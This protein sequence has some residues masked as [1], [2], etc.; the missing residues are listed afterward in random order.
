MRFHTVED[1]FFPMMDVLFKLMTLMQ[2][3][4]VEEQDALVKQLTQSQSMQGS[5]GGA[6][7]IEALVHQ[8][9][10]SSRHWHDVTKLGAALSRCAKSSTR[11]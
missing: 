6:S 10:T 2:P 9:E 4:G 1:C 5:G 7:R 11:G 3:K 8:R